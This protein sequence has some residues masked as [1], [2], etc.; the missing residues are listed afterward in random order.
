MS[1]IRRN[2][3]VYVG[4]LA[5][6]RV[7]QPLHEARFRALTEGLTS[8]SLAGVH[9]DLRDNHAFETAD[10][11]Q[12]AW[13]RIEHM[14]PWM[15]FFSDA[16]HAEFSAVDSQVTNLDENP[17]HEEGAQ[18]R[19]IRDDILGAVEAAMKEV[20]T[21]E[22]IATSE[23]VGLALS[24]LGYWVEREQVDGLVTGFEASR[25]HCKLL[26]QVGRGGEVTTDYI[27]LSGAESCDAS[28]RAFVERVGHYGVGLTEIDRS[29]HGDPRGGQLTR[30]AAR[31][32][33]RTLA[34]RIVASYD[35]PG[36]GRSQQDPSAMI[37]NEIA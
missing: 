11:V 31:A 2:S 8:A 20:A 24:D 4:N 6:I 18:V 33:G 19:A 17:A 16:V 25:D 12:F 9:A 29:D 15:S 5:A 27:G 34:Q 7:L 37:R 14:L 36:R 23:A 30:R 26:V 35:P 1:T 21:Y 13:T 22:Q 28:Q 3:A 10:D 32:P